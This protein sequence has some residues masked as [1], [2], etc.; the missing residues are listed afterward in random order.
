M[1]LRVMKAWLMAVCFVMAGEASANVAMFNAET[2]NAL[3]ALNGGLM[4]GTA[5]SA[6]AQAPAD[7][8]ALGAYVASAA[9]SDKVRSDVITRLTELGKASGMTEQ[10]ATALGQGLQQADVVGTTW[11]VLEGMGYPRDNLVTATAYW[12][13]VNWDMIQGA[14][15]TDVQGKAVFAQVSA[16]YAESGALAQMSDADKQYGAEAMLWFAILQ[17]EAYSSAQKAGNEAGIN[18]ARNDARTALKEM[19]FDAEQLQLGDTGFV[20]R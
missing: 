20:S 7:N 12:L 10:A 17:S 11:S 18:A 5:P 19:G 13:L 1:N 9:V 4:S 15:S 8:A 16:H 6:T 14:N 2:Q 3:Q